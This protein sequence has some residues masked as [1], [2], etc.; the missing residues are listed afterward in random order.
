MLEYCQKNYKQLRAVVVW[1]V[2]RLARNALDHMLVR[3]LL[4]RLGISLL[5]VNERL[6]DSPSGRFMEIVFAAAAQHDNDVRAD[7]TRKGMTASLAR[8]RWTFQ[9]PLGYVKQDGIVRID[10]AKGPLLREAF[11]RIA[12][13]AASKDQALALVTRKGLRIN[14]GRRY[15]L[16]TSAVFFGIR[17]TM[18]R[19]RRWGSNHVA[20]LNR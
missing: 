9:L 17:F 13:G 18:V 11:E 10:P 6:E 8:G 20:P 19:Y 14:R 4:Q 15:P 16:G 1:K 3:G 5:S 12:C 2:D 7:R